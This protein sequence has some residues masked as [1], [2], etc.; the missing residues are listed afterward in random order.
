[1]KGNR[2]PPLVTSS[3]P[4]SNGTLPTSAVLFGGKSIDTDGRNG[5][6]VSLGYWLDSEHR[7][8]LDAGLILLGFNDGTHFSAASSGSPLLARPFVNV[9][10]G[11]NDSLLIAAPGIVTGA[12]SVASGNRLQSGSFGLR[13]NW[14]RT[15]GYHIDLVA[16]YRYFRFQD[17]LTI[18]NTE[19]PTSPIFPPGTVINGMDHFSANNTFH[20]GEAG[21]E[22]ALHHGHWSLD[23]GGRVA[24]GDLHNDSKIAGSTQVG[25]TTFVGNLLALSSNIGSRSKDSFAVLP[26]VHATARYSFGKV[27]IG[28]GYSFLYLS[29]VLRTGGQI[30]LNVNPSLL[31]PATS[32][33]PASPQ[34]VMHQ[35]GFWAH[36]ISAGLQLHF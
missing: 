4:G 24:L 20:S 18:A 25:S 29:E 36:G 15:H 13:R 1:M 19:Q 28:V 31:P 23:L 9:L 27:S 11:A 21:L 22:G 2:L 34:P 16:G 8:G 30:D 32:G 6:R 7:L 3:P 33:G 5:G 35:T 12:V 26:Q 10:T 17:T 14:R